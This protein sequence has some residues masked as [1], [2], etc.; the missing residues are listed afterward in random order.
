MKLSWII[1][2]AFVCLSC[3]GQVPPSGGPPD[4]SPPKIIET[5]PLPGSIHYNKNKFFFSFN[6][7]IE[8]RTFQESFFISPSISGLSFKWNGKEVEVVFEDSLRPLTTYIITIGTDLMDTRGNR[9]DKAFSLPFSTGDI[10]DSFAISGTVVDDKSEGVM[11]FAYKLSG[12]NPDTLNPAQLKPDFLTQTGKDGTFLLPYLPEGNFRV[13][14][15]RDEY[16]NLLY[17]VQTDQFG[18]YYSDISLSPERPNFNGV[19]FRLALEDTSPPFLSSARAIDQFHVL[20]R[21]GEGIDEGSLIKETIKIV[22]TLNRKPLEIQDVSFAEKPV[23]NV[24]LTTYP[25]NFGSTYRVTVS[26]VKDLAGNYINQAQNSTEFE[27]SPIYDTL[28]PSF[29]LIYPPSDITE[30]FPTDTFRIIFSEAVQ[31]IKFTDGI[32]LKDS[33]YNIIPLIKYWPHSRELWLTPENELKS[34]VQYTLSIRMDS[35]A[36]LVGNSYPDSVVS[37]SYQTSDQ[38]NLS[39]ISGDIKDNLQNASGRIFISLNKITDRKITRVVQLDSTTSFRFDNLLEGRYTISAYRD[40]DGNGC[41]TTGKPF[42]FRSAE[43]FVV[44]P[45]TLKVRARWPLEGI[46][47]E[48]K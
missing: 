21:F 44:Y 9:L 33:S 28:R 46:L 12:R 47:I 5:S 41:Y 32:T 42:P 7:Y 8:R 20:L 14:A 34:G 4:K 24:Y 45:D 37:F 36:D 18:I 23:M 11:I 10:I 26:G 13:I 16:K 40:E 29:E 25:Q 3:A 30:I 15:V 19:Q 35:L 6:K 2:V 39:S 27:G 48:F 43:R 1:F 22:D 31:K 17:D 38:Q